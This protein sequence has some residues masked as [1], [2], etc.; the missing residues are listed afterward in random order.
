[1][2]SQSHWRIVIDAYVV[3]VHFQYKY[4]SIYNSIS[5]L[6][7]SC[8]F[9]NSTFIAIQITAVHDEVDH[10]SPV[11]CGCPFPNAALYASGG[12]TSVKVWDVA[13]TGKTLQDLPDAHSKA[14]NIDETWGLER[15]VQ[16][17]FLIL[18]GFG[19]LVVE[20][21]IWDGSSFHDQHLLKSA[22][23]LGVMNV[24]LMS[25]WQQQ[26]KFGKAVKVS[27]SIKLTQLRK[28]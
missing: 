21:Q 17:F 12:G 14:G 7:P 8:T 5:S 15:V 19:N 25:M 24:R 4:I 11:E 22:D 6:T 23:H 27:Q 20:F 18:G 2:M 10:G 3:T 13:M 9:Q 26:A 1:M 16:R 28:L